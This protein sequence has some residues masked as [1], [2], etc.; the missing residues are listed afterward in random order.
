MSTFTV[1]IASSLYLTDKCSQL[2]YSLIYSLFA[3]QCVWLPPFKHNIPYS[4]L[5]IALYTAASV[6]RA[7]VDP[8][9]EPCDGIGPVFFCVF[10]A[11]VSS[12]AFE[13]SERT[14][15]LSIQDL[16]KDA[17][18]LQASLHSTLFHVNSLQV[19]P[20]VRESA[21]FCQAPR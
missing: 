13:T 20:S 4:A 2:S 21:A 7:A 18:G 19:T 5:V 6:L 12:Y 11:L 1:E 10:V 9:G 3:L 16:E 15:F 17:A 14:T 8:S